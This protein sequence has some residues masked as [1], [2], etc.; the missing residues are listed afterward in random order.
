MNNERYLTIKEIITMPQF[1]STK[2]SEDGQKI[3]YVKETADLSDN[4][5]RKHI[6]KRKRKTRSTREV[7]LKKFKYWSFYNLI[8]LQTINFLVVIFIILVRAL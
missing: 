5:Y 6:W 8:W 1:I 4:I 3:A 2:I 7:V